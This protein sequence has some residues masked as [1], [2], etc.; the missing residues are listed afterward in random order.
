MSRP[1]AARRAIDLDERRAALLEGEPLAR[2]ADEASEEMR[3]VGLVPD[4]RDER[5]LTVRREVGEDVLRV[6]SG[7][8]GI[9]DG[10]HVAPGFR[11]D[12][13]GFERA[14]QRTREERIR[15]RQ[16][17]RQS[18]GGLPEP[19]ASAGREWA[20]P[21]IDV[22]SA[23]GDG[24]GVAHDEQLHTGHRHTTTRRAARSTR[25]GTCP[26]ATTR[27]RA[28]AVSPPTGLR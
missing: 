18:P 22:R 24:D 21:I 19:L 6:A 20:I 12:L 11:G 28:E 10:G 14:R 1:F 16:D 23:G 15:P 5:I 13:R 27:L 26:S 7:E 2:A 4:E 8:P 17:A 3:D 25:A 9:L